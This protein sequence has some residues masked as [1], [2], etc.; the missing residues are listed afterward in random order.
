MTSS[1]QPGSARCPSPSARDIIQQDEDGAPAALLTENY[2]FLGDVDLSLERYTSQSF[3]DE[4]I[5]KVWAKTW[6]WACREEHI[7]L[8]GDYQVYDVG[9]YSAFVVRQQDGSIKA[10]VNSCPHRAMQFFSAGSNGQGKQFLRCPF[11]GMS[12]HLDGTLRDIP[13]RWDFPHIQD[14][15]FGL[16]ELPTGTWGGF[17]FV[18][19]DT[20]AESLEE[21]LGVLPEHFAHC[22][23]ETRQVSLHLSKVMPGNWKMCVEAFLEAYH[24]L[25]THPEGARYTS[26]AAANYD[27][28]GKHVSRFE[29]N[30]G[31][32]SSHFK[33]DITAADIVES[34]G[35]DA[36]E[37][38]PGETARQFAAR[39]FRAQFGEAFGV[40]LSN[41]S[42]AELMDSIQ[43]FLFPNGFFFPGILLRLVYRFRPISVDE[44]LFEILVLDPLSPGQPPGKPADVIHLGADELYE[45]VEGFTFGQVFDQDTE[46]F[47]RQRAGMKAS[48]KKAE[49]L[50]NYQECRIRHLHATLDEYLGR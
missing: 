33:R 12:W 11:H 1:S 29:H 14:E 36:T 9:P 42:T 48:L 25:A 7:P 32:A 49:T 38:Q 27:V 21:Y 30:L 22:P 39:Q 5:E 46:N 16:M 4:E 20:G 43:Y 37:L 47:Y 26:D 45:S 6:Q 8:A 31:I 35:F 18:N 15:G 19:F 3:Y 13:C 23:L 50:A 34:M 41:I 2:R 44:C 28:F 17:V 40:D 10:F 24:V